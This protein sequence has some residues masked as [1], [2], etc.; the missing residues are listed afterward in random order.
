MFG[1][2]R[3]ISLTQIWRLLVCSLLFLMI[4]AT[5]HVI[6]LKIFLL[7]I[8]IFVGLLCNNFKINFEKW[9]TS[10]T[11]VYV[12]FN[13]IY[14]FYSFFNGNYIVT[15][16]M[17]IRIIEPLIFLII[18]SILS[19]DDY[20]FLKKM[21][22][23]I[24]FFVFV[25][26]IFSFLC[27]NHFVPVNPEYLPFERVDFGGVLPFGLQKA[28]SENN[29]WFYFLVPCSV[30]MCIND[31]SSM[32]KTH[33]RLIV[34]NFVLSCIVTIITLKT[35]LI[36]VFFTALVLSLIL[37]KLFLRR[38]SIPVNR[39]LV[40]IILLCFFIIL[41]FIPVVRSF[42]FDNLIEK[43]RISLGIGDVQANQY[44]VLDSGASIRIQQIND[45][46]TYWKKRPLFGWGDGANSPNIVRSNTSGFYEMVYFAKLMQ[47]GIIGL[48]IYFGLFYFVYSKLITIIKSNTHFSADAFV[49]FIGLS[50]MLIANATNPYIEAFDKLIIIFIPILLVKLYNLSIIKNSFD[51]A[52]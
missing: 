51:E 34:L 39:F 49:V 16:L 43:V 22:L 33:R 45:L 48:L 37:N 19:F 32:Q 31:N 3:L 20:V 2:S 5:G 17:N 35:A 44:G 9:S 30:A 21:I 41:F 12:L 25:Y 27:V 18:L 38:N 8:C 40:S 42:L 10:W 6:S 50:C 46:I 24:S 52:F 28:T 7:F 29:Q 4:W 26:S 11:V 23:Y 36:I 15:A 1:N 47:R 13:G 14:M